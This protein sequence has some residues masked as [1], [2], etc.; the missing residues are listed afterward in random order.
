MVIDRYSF[1]TQHKRRRPEGAV[2][3][4]LCASP[5]RPVCL[6]TGIGSPSLVCPSPSLSL[7]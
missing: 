5:G 1:L 7:S 4:L 3:G 6:A 2:S